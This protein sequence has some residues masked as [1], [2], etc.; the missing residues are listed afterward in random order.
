M[1]R[2]R[3]LNRQLNKSRKRSQK[4]SR[5]R[6]QKRSRKR[7][8]NFGKMNLPF[9]EDPIFKIITNFIKPKEFLKLI[10]YIKELSTNTFRQK[11]DESISLNLK[12]RFQQL[13]ISIF[14][15]RI[16]NFVEKM[17]PT[18][19]VL[20]TEGKYNN[21][22]K[23]IIFG[24]SSSDEEDKAKLTQFSEQIKVSILDSNITK[25][26]L[27]DIKKFIKSLS[28]SQLVLLL[29]GKFDLKN[30]IYNA[31][32]QTNYPT[33]IDNKELLKLNNEIS[34]PSKDIV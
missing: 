34:L 26:L 13:I 2:R 17:T 5:K 25:L 1:I 8:Q 24:R 4:R 22:M 20:L 27:G 21:E 31:S 16:N 15:Y 32:L 3:S 18:Q 6:S 30:A 19:I 10:I 29:N 14:R 7:S 23:N 33:K 28:N 12:E 11:P 9:Q